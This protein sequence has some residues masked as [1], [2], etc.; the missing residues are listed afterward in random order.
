MNINKQASNN[1]IMIRP[2]YFNYN[3]ETA[4]NNHFQKKPQSLTVDEI[5][6]KAIEE[7]EKLVHKLREKQIEVNVY[8]DRENIITTDSIFPNNW[9]SFHDDGKIILYPMFSKNRRKE[10]RQDI[11][12]NLKKNRFLIDEIIDL[13]KY[14]KKSLYLEGTGSM[15]LDRKNKICYAAL[16]ERTNK[17]VLI[18]FCKNLNY[19]PITFRAYHTVKGKRMEIYHTNVLMNVSDKYSIVCLDSIDS[20]SERKMVI[21]SLDSTEKK[22]ININENQMH[23]FAGN[24]LQ[25]ENKIGERFLVMS[26]TAFNSLEEIQKDK[27]LSFNDIIH[28]NL[29]TIETLGGGSARCMIAE[30]FLEKK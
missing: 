29:K 5:K 18:D 21:S 13:S 15:V 8:D 11:I 2:R 1:L 16:S 4:E 30:N 19:K 9:I 10:R 23:N 24:M 27:I 25:V 28:S 7:F 12:K 22:I 14:E 6:R 26:D 20:I 3:K 17:E